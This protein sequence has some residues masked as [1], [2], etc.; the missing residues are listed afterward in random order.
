MRKVFDCFTFYNEFDLLDL[1]LNE[2]NSVVD[3]FV[4]VEAEFTFR[5][6]R[7]P[8]YFDQFK[9][10][11]GRFKDKIIH[12]AIPNSFIDTVEGFNRN[13]PWHYESLQRDGVI[14]GL[15]QGNCENDDLIIQSD[16]DEIP[17]AETIEQ[18]L[19]IDR[20]YH[21]LMDL[22]FYKLNYR[23]AKRNKWNRAYI[24]PA[25]MLKIYPPSVYRMNYNKFNKIRDAGWHFSYF[26]DI[27]GIIK[28]LLSFSHV[29]Y[30]TGKYINPEFIQKKL[31]RGEDLFSD[32]RLDHISVD[33]TFP[34]C[35]IDNIEK[36]KQL[37]WID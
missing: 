10:N 2:L 13:N 6:N 25:R 9:A 35:I 29:E 20:K 7:K 24:S 14:L 19:N 11:Y 16:V 33:G 34:K 28:K 36:Y 37:G 30:S 32:E 22:F 5:G 12:I 4:L 26:N 3:K 17:R 1:R 23:F 8:L 15:Q 27:D 21:L 31:D 18:N